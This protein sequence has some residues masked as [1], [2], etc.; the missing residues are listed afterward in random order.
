MKSDWVSAKMFYKSISV[1]ILPVILR[2]VDAAPV[3][4]DVLGS[5]LT[6]VSSIRQANGFNISQ[7]P[8][9]CSSFTP[10][11]K[12]FPTELPEPSPG[13]SL[14]FIALGRG[15]QNYT[16]QDNN[17]ATVPVSNGATATLF[18]ASCLA[19]GYPDLLDDLPAALMHVPHDAAVLGALTLGQ[20]SA[21]RNGSLV[22]GEHYF[23]NSTTPFFDF[24]PFGHPEWIAAKSAQSVQ[25]PANI[26]VNGS[27]A[28]LQ[29]GYREGVGI[30]VGG[31]VEFKSNSAADSFCNRKSIE[32]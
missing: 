4:Q 3:D 31:I 18:D 15:T 23:R 2:V 26:S 1:I 28:W 9:N 16:C 27:V 29:L 24:R 20:F 30:Q 5:T 10:I 14:K 7:C 19:A 12:S 21:S 13:L 11:S 22:I 6:L 32:L 25:A 8:L 17:T